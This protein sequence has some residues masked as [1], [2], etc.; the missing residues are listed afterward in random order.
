MHQIDP[1]IKMIHT[2]QTKYTAQL[3]ERTSWSFELLSKSHLANAD[4]ELTTDVITNKTIGFWFLQQTRRLVE[5][6]FPSI[7]EMIQQMFNA[8]T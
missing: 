5:T 3:I 7:Y 4:C 6:K 2:Q 1:E 8:H